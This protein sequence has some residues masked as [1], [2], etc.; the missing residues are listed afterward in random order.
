MESST[1][2]NFQRHVERR[3][4]V[5]IGEVAVLSDNLA[6]NKGSGK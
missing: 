1:N 3:H 6:D 4:D 5:S 2:R